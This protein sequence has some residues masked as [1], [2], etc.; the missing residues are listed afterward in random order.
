MA[1][2]IT[3]STSMFDVSGETPNPINPI[4]GQ[5]IL[6]WIRAK[7]V[8]SPYTATAPEP[9]DWGWYMDVTG[10]DAT[11]LVGASAEAEHQPSDTDWTIQIHKHR[12]AM[13]KLTGR[14]R[15]AADDAF[16]ALVETLFRETPGFRN[17]EIEKEA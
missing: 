5:S 16:V 14:N 2:V 17:V 11:Y 7:L 1:H 15:L 6:T 4:A 8:G 13:E 3:L 9:E 10:P 12:T